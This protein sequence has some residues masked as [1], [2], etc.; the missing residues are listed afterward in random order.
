M[1]IYEAS[2]HRICITLS[3]AS[4]DLLVV[5]VALVTLEPGKDSRKSIDDRYVSS[6]PHRPAPHSSTYLL[7]S[8][9]SLLY[10]CTTCQNLW[11]LLQRY[12]S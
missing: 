11:M 7:R 6:S 2:S 1:G 5:V 10:G 4:L 9:S 3:N 8:F 12:P